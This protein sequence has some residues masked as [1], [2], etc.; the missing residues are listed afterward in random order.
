MLSPVSPNH[1]LA[2][3]A[4]EFQDVWPVLVLATKLGPSHLAVAQ[5]PPQQAFGVG[6]GPAELATALEEGDAGMVAMV[7][8]GH[9]LT[10]T[11]SQREREPEG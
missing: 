3:M 10:L 2:L 6:A 5:E 11:L 4:V 7:G 9:A 1:Q 8:S